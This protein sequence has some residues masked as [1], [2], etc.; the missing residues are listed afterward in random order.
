MSV[1]MH[2]GPGPLG[3]P[4]MTSER[5]LSYYVYLLVS[6][7][8]GTL[9]LGVVPGLSARYRVD[10]L[11]WFEV[12]DDPVNAITHEKELKKWLWNWKIRLI[13]E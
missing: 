9:Y 8:H 7:R 1:V 13:V 4:G 12:Y 6:R 3:R 11:I 10:R 5:H 2:S